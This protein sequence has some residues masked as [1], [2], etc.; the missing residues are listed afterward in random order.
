MEKKAKQFDR[1]VAEWK[2][3]TD[4]LQV[5]KLFQKHNFLNQIFR[6]N[7]I[8]ASWNAGLTRLNCSKLRLLTKKFRQFTTHRHFS[9]NKG[10][11]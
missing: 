8:K 11:I 2:A 3:K 7:W 9:V 10:S 1:V 6:L 4:G 5:M